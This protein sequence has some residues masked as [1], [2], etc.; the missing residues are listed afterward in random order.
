VRR[1]GRGASASAASRPEGYVNS[2]NRLGAHSQAGRTVAALSDVSGLL[3]IDAGCTLH[4]WRKIICCTSAWP[5]ICGSQ[6]HSDST[7]LLRITQT[8]DSRQQAFKR[9]LRGN[10]RLASGGKYAFFWS[11]NGNNRGGQQI[12]EIKVDMHRLLVV[13]FRRPDRASK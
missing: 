12:F 5:A 10:L 13:A 9:R 6:A 3:E 11:L 1:A 2:R 7:R 8:G 4:L